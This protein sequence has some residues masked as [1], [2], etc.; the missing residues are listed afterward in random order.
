M[1]SIYI[2]IIVVIIIAVVVTV[3][4]TKKHQPSSYS[5]NSPMS[6]TARINAKNVYS[7]STTARI[8]AEIVYSSEVLK[9]YN[10]IIERGY[11]IIQGEIKI[12][13]SMRDGLQS[14]INMPNPTTSMMPPMMYKHSSKYLQIFNLA[15]KAYALIRSDRLP[16]TQEKAQILGFINQGMTIQK[17]MGVLGE[18]KRRPTN[19]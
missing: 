17:E 4:M 18:M 10:D 19:M 13:T 11:N 7:M 5:T 9:A 6:S 15:L 8:N 1:K 3:I 16:N 2:A 14:Y 12:L